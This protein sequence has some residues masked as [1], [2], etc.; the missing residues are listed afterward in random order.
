MTAIDTVK[1]AKKLAEERFK[2][3]PS[4]EIFDSVLKQLIYLLNVLEKKENDKTKL[5]KIIVGHYAVHEFEESDPEFS[6]C[7]KECQNIA[8][9]LSKGKPV[10]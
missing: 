8:I 10:H 6:R 4:F 2:A 3:A 1:K 5:K 7:L 9:S